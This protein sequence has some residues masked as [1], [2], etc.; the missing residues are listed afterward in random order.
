MRK[1]V[2]RGH[3][4]ATVGAVIDDLAANH[5][6]CDARHADSYARSRAERGYGP[7]RI[8]AEL[9]QRGAPAEALVRALQGKEIDWIERARRADV[10]RFGASPAT[11]PATRARR[12]RFLEYRGFT[13][14]QIRAVVD[15]GHALERELD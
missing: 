13:S 8:Q 3:A 12:R 5:L 10:K 6:Q 11:D 2:A 15:R 7:Q 9:K 4:A 1:L 14:E